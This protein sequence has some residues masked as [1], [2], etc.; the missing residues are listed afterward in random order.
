MKH[1]PYFRK[2]KP[3][4]IDVSVYAPGSETKLRDVNAPKK[5]GQTLMLSDA[6]SQIQNAV[7]RLRKHCRSILMIGLIV[8]ACFDKLASFFEEF[9]P[10][11]REGLK[12]MRIVFS[13]GRNMTPLQQQKIQS[14]ISAFLNHLADGAL[15]DRMLNQFKTIAPELYA[16]LISLA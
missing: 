9:V 7:D 4:S 15:A 14:I 16:K 13:L 1:L 3:V 6:P 12:I 10:A 8:H 11:S 5:H 2:G